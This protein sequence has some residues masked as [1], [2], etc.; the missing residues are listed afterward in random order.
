VTRLG[1]FDP[2]TSTLTVLPFAS[3]NMT[4]RSIR[5]ENEQILTSPDRM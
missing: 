1:D 5:F 2:K 4:E 3:G